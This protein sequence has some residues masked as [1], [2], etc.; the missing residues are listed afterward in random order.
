MKLESWNLGLGTKTMLA[1][2]LLFPSLTGCLFLKPYTPSARLCGDD[3]SYFACKLGYEKSTDYTDDYYNY[4]HHFSSDDMINYDVNLGYRF[5]IQA[6]NFE[7]GLDLQDMLSFSADL[8]Y[9]IF[10]DPKKSP[11]LLAL[12]AALFIT[13]YKS[14]G[15][16]GAVGPNLNFILVDQW[17]LDLVLAAY[18]QYY[19]YKDSSFYS[20]SYQIPPPSNALYFYAGIEFLSLNNSVVS[21]GAGYIYFINSS[22]AFDPV[23][24]GLSV[25]YAAFKQEKPSEASKQAI[26]QD[27]EPDFYIKTARKFIKLNQY[28]SAADVL[29]KGLDKYPDDYFLNNLMGLCCY[30]SGDLRLAY[31]YYKKALDLNPGDA[32]LGKRLK[33]IESELTNEKK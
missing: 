23:T 32:A 3:P 25:K 2:F 8:K 12:D 5:R 11:V 16:G 13:S 15:I 28:R 21:L 6:T 18:Y 22:Y 10:P 7:F 33:K 31:I 9:G 27:V 26:T 30:K 4:T 17:A 1:L 24:F 20:S 29:A 14:Y 19:D